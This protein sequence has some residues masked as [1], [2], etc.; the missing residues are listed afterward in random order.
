MACL[1]VARS[2]SHALTTALGVKQPRLTLA[3][4]AGQVLPSLSDGHL[5]VGGESL[6]CARVGGIGRGVR[7]CPDLDGN[8]N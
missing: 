4:T 5:G 3:T 1:L 7:T 6:V 8:A 2:S